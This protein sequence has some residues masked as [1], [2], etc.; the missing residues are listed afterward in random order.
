MSIQDE[1]NKRLLKI[2]ELGQLA[3]DDPE[4]EIFDRVIYKH[5]KKKNK[6][7]K[8]ELPWRS[9]L[10]PLIHLVQNKTWITNHFWILLHRWFMQKRVPSQTL[11]IED[12][13]FMLNNLEK[14]GTKKSQ[15]VLE[16]FKKFILA[17]ELLDDASPFITSDPVN[18]YKPNPVFETTEADIS[19]FIEYSS[20]IIIKTIISSFGIVEPVRA[21]A[22]ERFPEFD[23]MKTLDKHALVS[24]SKKIYKH[25]Y[26]STAKWIDQE[27]KALSEDFPMYFESG[28]HWGINKLPNMSDFDEMLDMQFSNRINFAPHFDI[29]LMSLDYLQKLIISRSK[30]LTQ[31]LRNETYNKFV[32]LEELA[33][34]IGSK[35]TKT[36]RNEFFKDGNKLSYYDKSKKNSITLK[37]AQKWIKD[38]KRKQP[39]YESLY[40][41]SIPDLTLDYI[42][43]L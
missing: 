4:L 36:I 19:E 38:P 31:T 32:T 18:K 2:K 23:A 14:N 33:L 39:I 40:D 12:I 37:S 15:K 27:K 16:K 3:K 35:S 41:D 7:L 6:I 5:D 21:A 1:I 8:H 26:E 24:A 42:M 22:L 43:E 11:D 13:T 29:Y 25:N 17:N 30:L 34:V 20:N 10:M 28:L 9:F